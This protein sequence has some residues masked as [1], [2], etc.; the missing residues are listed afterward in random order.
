[1]RKYLICILPPIIIILVNIFFVSIANV[2]G[3]SM[4]PNLYDG[5]LLIYQKFS[6]NF[7]RFDIIVVEYNNV[8]YIKR[9]IGLPGEKIEYKDNILYINNEKIEETFLNDSVVTEDFTL[10]DITEEIEYLPKNTYLVLGDNRQNSIDSRI[11]SY[12]SIENILG[13]VKF[14]IFPFNRFGKI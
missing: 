8:N 6:K 11:F 7:E 9:I 3:V 10:L 12:I 5:D 1:M 2:V 4:M 14:K 13:E